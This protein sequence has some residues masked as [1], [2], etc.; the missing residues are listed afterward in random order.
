MD[1]NDKYRPAPS[2]LDAYTPEQ[3]YQKVQD[4]SRAK[5]ITPAYKQ[6]ML[7]VI[8]GGYISLGCI[9][10]LFLMA[11][12]PDAT[13]VDLFFSGLLFSSGYIMAVLAGAEVFTSS[14]L[15]AMSW[16]AGTMSSGRIIF[17]WFIILL[18]NTIGALSLVFLALFS[19]ILWQGEADDVAQFAFEVARFHTSLGFTEVFF[20]AVLGNMV[21]CI[22][23]WISFAGRSVT[24]KLLPMSLII[25][26]VPILELE[27]ISASLFYVPLGIL[28]PILNPG[29]FEPVD[30]ITMTST[31]VYLSAV[32]L[33]NIIGGGGLV[34]LVYYV[35]YRGG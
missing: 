10:Y 21:I 25:S 6:M 15:Q 23:I 26:S 17:R 16:A 12:N 14:N 9:F 7:G 24:D 19:G 1:Q 34:A 20:R 11:G 30:Q 33:G 3:V 8:A 2:G 29:I 4:Y 31:F 18:A 13:G 32:T 28:L 22:A 5:L 27:H 35:I